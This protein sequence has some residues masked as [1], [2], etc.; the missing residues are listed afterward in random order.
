MF[1]DYKLFS[2]HIT[3]I[4]SIRAI[5]GSETF[6]FSSYITLIASI[7]AIEGS[8]TFCFSSL[9]TLIASIRAIE[10][11]RNISLFITK[12]KRIKIFNTILLLPQLPC[13]FIPGKMRN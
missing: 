10:G 1:M 7:R 4:E 9:I 3:L 6:S 2:Y 8:E 13:G 11:W 5:E 12:K